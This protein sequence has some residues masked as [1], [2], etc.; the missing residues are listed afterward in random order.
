MITRGNIEDAAKE[1]DFVV[2]GESETGAQEHLYMETQSA[3]VIPRKE[4]KE[5]DVFTSTQAVAELQV[6]HVHFSIYSCIRGN[7]WCRQ[8]TALDNSPQGWLPPTIKAIEIK[9]LKRFNLTC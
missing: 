8:F 2:E 6:T 4:Q 1:A 7:R 3:L 5:I 9:D